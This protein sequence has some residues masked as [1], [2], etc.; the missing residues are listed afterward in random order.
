MGSTPQS[1]PF[2]LQLSPRTESSTSAS[3]SSLV[4]YLSLGRTE[5]W[6]DDL[7]DALRDLGDDRTGLLK[8]GAGLTWWLSPNAEIT[9]EYQFMGIRRPGL[10]LR[11]SAIDRA[12]DTG[13]D[14]L[15]L[16][17]NLSIKY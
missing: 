8:T 7:P 14:A 16:S 1:L 4:P 6:N 3:A 5:M 2:R 9:G 13:L 10:S 11:A 12:V 15:G 17:L